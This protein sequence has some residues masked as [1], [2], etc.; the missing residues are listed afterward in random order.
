MGTMTVSVYQGK[1]SEEFTFRLNTNSENV[2]YEWDLDGDGVFERAT[3]S[4]EIKTTFTKNM[5]FYLQVRATNSAG[6][7][8]TASAHVIISSSST[9]PTINNIIYEL[10]GN[11]THFSY[12]FGPDTSAVLVAVNGNLIGLTDEE[13]FILNDLAQSTMVSLVPVGNSGEQGTPITFDLSPEGG[14]G[15]EVQILAPNAGAR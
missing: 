3:A 14:F 6:L 5:D 11:S 15:A 2:K 13:N 9:E 7:S 8:S 12:Q 1:P 4:P 10:N